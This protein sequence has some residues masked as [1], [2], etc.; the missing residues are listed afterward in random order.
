MNSVL[1]AFKQTRI[2]EELFYYNGYLKCLKEKKEENKEEDAENNNSL[3]SKKFSKLM[4]R[5]SINDK[6]PV[7]P[8]SMKQTFA[9]YFPNVKIESV[10]LHFFFVFYFDYFN[11]LEL[12]STFFILKRIIL[13]RIK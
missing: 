12:I 3:L 11:F 8:W 1:Q 9:F 5:L 10:F 4:K 2:P 13:N 6:D 7:A